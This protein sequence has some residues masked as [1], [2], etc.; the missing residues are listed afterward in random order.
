MSHGASFD[1]LE[2]GAAGGT[3][4]PTKQRYAYVLFRQCLAEFMGTFTLCSTVALAAGQG[5]NLMAVAGLAI[6]IVL[7][8]Q[9]FAFGHVS[10]AHF[11]PAVTLAVLLRGKIDVVSALFY[12]MTQLIASFSAG[13]AI[14]AI[15]N[16]ADD[17]S[18]IMSGFPNP[19]PNVSWE[20]VLFIEFFFTM[21]LCSVV[22]N[23]ATTKAQ[24]GNSFFGLAIG[25]VIAGAAMSGGGISGGAYNPA[26]G[27]G[28]PLVYGE[29][30]WV[31]AYWVGPCLGAAAA[32]GLFRITADASEFE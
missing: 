8:T 28:L 12:T 23:V 30:S 20:S 6:G 14:K 21:V 18:V 26:V 31:W 10:G 9:V 19:H 5:K 4:G 13:G 22:L 29:G 2:S 27:T 11:N 24:E 1:V 7:A 15:V 32:A 25:F 17:H 16:D 3:A